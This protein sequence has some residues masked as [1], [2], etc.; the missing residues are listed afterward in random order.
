MELKDLRILFDSGVLTSATVS[1]NILGGGYIVT[2][3]G[4]NNK[5][6]VIS[7]QRSKSEARIFKSIDAAVKN[8]HDIGFK[9]ITVHFQR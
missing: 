8:T 7:R 3:I 6:Y 2:I 1:P 4:K 5:Q 9:T